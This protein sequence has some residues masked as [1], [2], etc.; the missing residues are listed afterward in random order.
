MDFTDI[1][2][3]WRNLS[4]QDQCC[5]ISD[6]RNLEEPFCGWFSP[7]LEKRLLRANMNL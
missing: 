6:W 3:T 7:M 2:I 4:L 5:K 1:L